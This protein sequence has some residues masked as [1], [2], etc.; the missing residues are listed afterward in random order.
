MEVESSLRRLRKSNSR[1]AESFFSFFPC[2]GEKMFDNTSLLISVVI[3]GLIISILG[4]AQTIYIQKE[5]FQPK[6]ALRDFFIG[7]IIVTF[8]YQ[9]V[10]ESVTG[11]GSLLKDVKV[12][13]LKSLT[14][15]AAPPSLNPDFDLQVGVPRF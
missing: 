9:I 7:A 12:P 10:P 8:L 13:D 1:E 15:G 11:F 14:G 3:G 6:G 2:G 5:E 4:T